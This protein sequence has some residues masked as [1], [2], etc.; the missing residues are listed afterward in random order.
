M[1]KLLVA[2]GVALLFVACVILDH[3]PHYLHDRLTHTTRYQVTKRQPVK[4]VSFDY[5]T[6]VRTTIQTIK[7]YN[8]FPATYLH[9]IGDQCSFAG[10]CSGFW[11]CVVP[12][13]SP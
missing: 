3:N 9:D 8:C 12:S 2:A 1:H 4:S 13:N 7:G 10:I 5:P 6:Y 11:H